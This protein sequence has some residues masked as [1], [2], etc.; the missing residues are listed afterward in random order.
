MRDSTEQ[1]Y[2][3]RLL[4]VLVYIQ[5][6][7]HE[8]VELD[9]LAA[10]ANF[11]PFHFHR[12]F[13]GMIG[14][15]V[16][17]HVRRLRLECAA[18]ALIQTDEPITRIAFDAGYETAD[19]F[20]RAFR[21]LFGM[22]PSGYRKE[23]SARLPKAPPSGVHFDPAHEVRDFNLDSQGDLNMDVELKTIEPM[24]IAFA[25]A[26]GSYG[27]S[28]GQAWQKIC[29]WAGPRGLLGPKT[30]MIGMSHDNPDITAA[31]KIRYD[32]CITL[33]RD[34]A[35]EGEIG[36]QEI[37]GG[38]HAVIIHKGPYEAM[39]ETYNFLYGQWLP[40]SGYRPRSQAGMEIYRN[41]PS[42]TPPAELLTEICVPV[43]KA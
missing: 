21:D 26:V 35:P 37:G 23:K 22:T 27:E 29:T 17:E 2:K 7:L 43:E 38:L 19:A 34:V 16:M 24:K 14:E 41:D 11:S 33:N 10:L 18:G 32:A 39:S 36:V 4:R 1:D 15:S 20:T 13:R 3:Q 30:L 25:R 40:K 42:S 28:A 12:I 31:D 8:T 6:H 9:E 5:N